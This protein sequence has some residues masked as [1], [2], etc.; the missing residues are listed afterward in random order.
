M[1]IY[2]VYAYLRNKDSKTAK[3]GTP[4]YIGKGK[5]RRAWNTHDS[6]PV[7][8]D[9]HRIVILESNLT[10]LG[11]W[12]LERRLIDWWG[13]KTIDGGILHNSSH[14]GPR[15][16]LGFNAGFG[17]FKDADGNVVS[18]RTN[19]PRVLAGELVG[20][21]K[22]NNTAAIKAAETIRRR[23]VGKEAARKGH[24]TRVAR[25]Q[26]IQET[27]RKGISTK[28]ANNIPIGGTRDGYFKGLETAKRNGSVIGGTKESNRRSV[29]TKRR[30]GFFEKH[31]QH[32]SAMMS[33]K[34]QRESVKTLEKLA[35]ILSVSLGKGWKQRSDEW[36]N[37]KISE[38][39]HSQ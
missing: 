11:A 17:I 4:Y 31:S 20:F 7:P 22:G 38:L 2:Y 27:C 32:L 35:D 5:G 26:N 18:A 15:G 24:A 33:S 1:N 21:H 25:G 12:A 19:D 36:V 23:G 28:I 30:D 14:G 37:S 3:A 10:E 8:K 13:R 9:T 6:I 16:S 29:E 39:T 34:A